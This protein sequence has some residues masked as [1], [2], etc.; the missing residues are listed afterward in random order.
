MPPLGLKRRFPSMMCVFFSFLRHGLN[1]SNATNSPE[2]N[3]PGLLPWG[4]GVS[5]FNSSIARS[6]MSGTV[7][8]WPMGYSIS[9]AN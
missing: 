1:M 9:V 7:W 2:T 8:G 3:A 4:S 5:Q 6:M